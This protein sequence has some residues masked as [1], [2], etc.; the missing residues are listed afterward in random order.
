M[1]TQEQEN[2]L[3]EEKKNKKDKKHTH[4][5]CDEKIKELEEKLANAESDVLR[6]KA[7]MINY[8][9]RKDDEVSNMLKYANSDLLTS[10]LPVLDNFERALNVNEETINDELKN[11][12][13]GFKMIY[14]SL[15][16]TIE[17]YGVKEI[18][19][20]GKTFD[21]KYENCL[22]TESDNDKEDEI[23]LDVLMKGYMLND[24]ILRCASVKVNKIDASN[25]EK[26]D[27]KNE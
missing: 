6:A 12:L 18:D 7:D 9:K 15:K 24:K 23:V 8:R 1:S 20:L 27:D 13:S 16:E 10:L 4:H 19:C 2:E 14:A 17:S 11:F 25:K 21:S 5:E 22:F 26:E 3:K